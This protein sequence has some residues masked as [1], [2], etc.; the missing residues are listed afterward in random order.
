MNVT[1][2]IGNGFD[3]NLGLATTYSEFVKTYKDLPSDSS[4]IIGFREH[5]KKNEELWSAAEIELGKYTEKLEKGKGAIFS[6]CH[7][8]ICE[9]LANYLKVQQQRIDYNLSKEEIKY[10][11]AKINEITNGFPSEERVVLNRVYMNYQNENINFNFICFNYTD[12]LDRCLQIAENDST[13]KGSHK[14]TSGNTTFVHNIKTVCHVHGTV[15]KEMVFGVNDDTQITNL[16]VFECEYG[17]IYKNLLIKKKANLSYQENTDA[18]ALDILNESNIIYI[19][20]MSLGDTDKLWW[21]RIC[22][23]LAT[24]KEHQLI[25][26]DHD[27]P[28][29][30][31]FPIKYQIAEKLRKSKM[32]NYSEFSEDKK[33]ALESQIHIIGNNIFEDMTDIAISVDDVDKKYLT[34]LDQINKEI[35]MGKI[36][37]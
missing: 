32:L 35:S 10:G 34:V 2:L 30:G 9:E 20:G 1:F 16:E 15:D 29:K 11:I 36:I 18:I 37:E 4:N 12:T 31:V 7:A 25:I 8:D 21:E 22:K 17:D 26:Q 33:N 3:R 28:P 27:M 23:W 13:V 24:S 6:E 19:Y 14:S 5:I